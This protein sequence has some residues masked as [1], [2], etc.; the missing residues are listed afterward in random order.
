[1]FDVLRGLRNFRTK[2]DSSREKIEDFQFLNRE[3]ILLLAKIPNS[4]ADYDPAADAEFSISTMTERV[5]T[6]DMNRKLVAD[7]GR[8]LQIQLGVIQSSEKRIEKVLRKI[9]QLER[10]TEPLANSMI[11]LFSKLWSIYNWMLNL[12]IVSSQILSVSPTTSQFSPAA[13]IL[14][15]LK[16]RNG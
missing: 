4:M 3:I 8:T 13:I 14:K 11:V 10:G 9:L 15:I 1:L 7:L 16:S 12:I 2:L 5:E 6:H